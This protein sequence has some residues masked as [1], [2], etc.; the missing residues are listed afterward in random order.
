[1]VNLKGRD[2]SEDLGIVEK[3]ILESILGKWGGKVWNECIWLMIGNSG[4]LL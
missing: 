1:L 4:E 2:H 3:I